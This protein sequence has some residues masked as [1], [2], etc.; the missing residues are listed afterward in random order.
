MQTPAITQTA[1]T[2]NPDQP[3]TKHSKGQHRRCRRTAGTLPERPQ[4]HHG[5]VRGNRPAR[6]RATTPSSGAEVD[7]L[8]GVWVRADTL[9]NL[10]RR[11]GV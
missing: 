9:E 2:E 6:G 10:A 11:L 8:R 3:S 1:P 7:S 5:G 4:V